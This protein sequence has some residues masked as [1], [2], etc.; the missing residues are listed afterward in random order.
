MKYFKSVM[1]IEGA[2]NVLVMERRPE[3]VSAEIHT[4]MA[5]VS[6]IRIRIR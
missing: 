2:R 3:N 1:I 5:V 4:C 6:G